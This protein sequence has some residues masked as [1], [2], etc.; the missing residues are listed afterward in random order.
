MASEA[1]WNAVVEAEDAKGEAAEAYALEL[2]DDARAKGNA[3]LA[4]HWEEVASELH[5][6]HRINR[7][8]ARLRPRP[9]GSPS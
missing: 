8:W 6:L 4:A 2:A 7:K 1:V 3:A 9:F 5:T